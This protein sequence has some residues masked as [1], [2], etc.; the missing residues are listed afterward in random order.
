M[1]A[2]DVNRIVTLDVIRGIAVMGIFSV[3]VVTFAMPVGAYFNPAGFGSGHRY[4]Y[5]LWLANFVLIDGKM[6]GLFTLLFGASTM[7]VI[8]RAIA[9]GRSPA[10]A[11]YARMITLLLLGFAHFYLIWFGDI[12][13]LYALCGIMLFGVRRWPV[14]WLVAGAITL[15]L[16]DV[17]AMGA[18]SASLLAT[19]AAISRPMPTIDTLESWRSLNEGFGKL[20]PKALA[21]DLALYRSNWNTIMRH[22]LADQVTEPFE[23]F[24]FAGPETLGYMLVGAAGYRSGFL[25]GCWPAIRYRKIAQWTILPGMAGFAV[26]AAWMWARGFD[27]A[28]VATA[29]FF[30]AALPRLA[31]ILGYAALI[32]FAVQ[33][34]PVWIARVAAVGR[35][36]LSNYLSTSIAAGF[37]FYGYGLGLYGHV[38]RGQ[39]W[40]VVPLFWLV[41]LSWSKPWLERFRYG[42]FEWLWRSLSR[43][44]LA[45]LQR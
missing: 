27:P 3:N 43:G 13:T 45:L 17:I 9:T 20:D 10:L 8:D 7:L 2:P 23:Q 5:V 24:G 31:M 28:V 18:M 21:S 40:I 25:T 19:S 6:R 39:A 16:I 4:D 35:C 1:T 36:A 41:M 11:H 15:L 29:Q 30:G 42:P 12:L 26:L 33:K 34:Q 38:S 32:A 22:R 14:H 37:V 44:K